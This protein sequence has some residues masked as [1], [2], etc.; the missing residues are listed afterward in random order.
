MGHEPAH[1]GL[2]VVVADHAA[3]EARRPGSDPGLVEEED[4]LSRALAASFELLA[5]VPRGGE[6]VHSG[7]D[8]DEARAVGLA[9]HRASGRP[10]FPSPRGSLP[11]S[12]CPRFPS[13]RPTNPISAAE[14][15]RACA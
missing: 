9:C 6:A 8:H 1:R 11:G 12:P 10:A 13:P 2:E 14:T 15:W 4:A 3:G 7:P 5:K